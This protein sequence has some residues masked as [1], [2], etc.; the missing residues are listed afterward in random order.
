MQRELWE[1]PNAVNAGKG[2]YA[3]G[4]L[5]SKVNVTPDRIQRTV[6]D[7]LALYC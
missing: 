6:A 5:R 3:H 1:L 4:I 7:A 2:R